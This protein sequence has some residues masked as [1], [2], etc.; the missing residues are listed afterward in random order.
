MGIIKKTVFAQN[1]DRYNA[2]LTD[3]DTNSRYFRVTQIPDVF[4]GG[5]NA[6]LIQGS[7][8]LANGSYLMI[9]IK[10]A[11]GN[12]IYYEPAFGSPDYYEGTSKPVAVYIYTDT[13]F[14]PCT[15]TILGELTQYEI[16][17][18]K[19]PIPDN[20][21]GVPNVKWQRR[22]N[23][24]PNLKNTTPIRFYKRP[25]A[26]VTEDLLPVYERAANLVSEG[27]YLKA[28]MIEPSDGTKFPFNGQITYIIESIASGSTPVREFNTVPIESTINI[29]NITG[30]EFSAIELNTSKIRTNPI[31]N[32]TP[33]TLSTKITS[34]ID[35]Y[36]AYVT[37][38]YTRLKN[39][40]QFYRNI[41]MARWDT[42]YES[43]TS[44]IESGYSSSY[45]NIKIQNLDTFTGDVARCKVFIKSKNSVRGYQLLEDVVVES[46]EFF[47]VPFLENDIN[48]RTGLFTKNAILQTYWNITNSEGSVLISTG[49]FPNLYSVNLV[50]DD[51]KYYDSY[52]YRFAYSQNIPFKKE[53]EYQLSFTPTLTNVD[54]VGWPTNLDGTYDGILH[55]Y[56]TSSAGPNVDGTFTF[57]DSKSNE[58]YG[59]RLLELRLPQ[60]LNASGSKAS[61]QSI[62][63]LADNDGLGTISFNILRGSWN[64]YDISL[65]SYQEDAFTPNEISFYTKP[66]QTVVSESFDFNFE[67][68]DTNFNYVPVRVTNQ[69]QFLG[70]SDIVPALI[71]SASH[72]SFSITPDGLTA[73]PESISIDYSTNAVFPGY[74]I[75][76]Q[77]G[78]NG[79]YSYDNQSA[80]QGGPQIITPNSV[81]SGYPYPGLLLPSNDVLLPQRRIL[82]WANFSSSLI[83]S[84]GG[85]VYSSLDGIR[86]VSRVDYKIST[87]GAADLGNTLLATQL[88]KNLT[89]VA[90]Y[91]RLT[92]TTT[93][94]TTSTTTT[95]TTTTSTTST[96]TTSTTNALVAKPYILNSW[97]VN[98]D[99]VQ[100]LLKAN[101]TIETIEYKVS[102]NPGASYIEMPL[103]YGGSSTNYPVS[104]S[105]FFLNNVSILN[106][107]N[108]TG[109]LN[110]N[111]YDIRLRLKWNGTDN[112]VPNTG[113]YYPSV[114][115]GLSPAFNT[116]WQALPYNQGN[117]VYANNVSK[118]S[119]D[120][121]I[122]YNASWTYTFN[123][124]P[125]TGSVFGAIRFVTDEI[126][127]TVGQDGEVTPCCFMPGTLISMA[128]GTLKKIENIVNNDIVLSYDFNLGKNVP[129]KVLQLTG[130]IR[131]IIY[132]VTFEDGKLVEMTDDH[133]IYTKVNG[134]ASINP[135]ASK[136]AYGDYINQLEINDYAMISTGEYVK[137]LD[138][139][140]MIIVDTKTYSFVTENEHSK[141]YYANGILAHNVEDGFCPAA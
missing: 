129:N 18:I 72:V 84:A 35:S 12:T 20:W 75:S 138:I 110:A 70:G 50:P 67:F 25:V 117:K 53:K 128:D 121:A 74:G 65:K 140:E 57:N 42:S 115:N 98:D 37:I 39:N 92:T 40:T 43:G 30:F 16:G 131:N 55:V 90:N 61:K 44:F 59:K 1:L 32:F 54:S 122:D 14:G 102:S 73:Q 63:F 132:K 106:K 6:F 87:I 34:Y 62:N 29:S 38:P 95:S 76:F 22:V 113:K 125:L 134:W 60:P 108:L 26:T 89:V 91:D 96:S 83:R 93:T 11:T 45:A 124:V 120:S 13:A 136:V 80:S 139:E 101:P 111:T 97:N 137:I 126:Q 28:T 56:A 4:T 69:T 27:G 49:S 9:E 123:N 104:S 127:Q 51:D 66:T 82:T 107:S 79:V 3:T 133:P 24:N 78:S 15:I 68:F 88:T 119:A 64:L 85:E 130:P 81:T 19:Y 86:R 58:P 105:G 7:T 17:G 23:V 10:D 8:E 94:T 2:F 36:R 103:N 116:Y 112:T 41:E 71:V 109:S 114:T 47:Q 52:S 48:V 100:R 135:I 33:S 5:K 77:T 31:V 21:I 99:D 46:N 141:N 118:S